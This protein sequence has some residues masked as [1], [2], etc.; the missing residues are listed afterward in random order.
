MREDVLLEKSPLRQ[1]TMRAPK[2]YSDLHSIVSREVLQKVE[3]QI[4]LFHIDHCWAEYLA[5]VAHI[6]EGIHLFSVSGQNPL[7]EFHKIIAD[8][9]Q[10]LIQTI[11]DEIIKT[12]ETAEI[13]KDGIDME[14]EGLESPSSTW[15]YLI[16]DN[17]FGDWT[18]RVSRAF[19]KL[20]RKGSK[21]LKSESL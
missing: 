10:N 7:D 4:T 8:A 18:E 16:N 20:F 12:F 13:T 11:D 5:H 14:K 1:L 15:T 17:P 3:K 19:G 9:F 6:R 21:S 2:R